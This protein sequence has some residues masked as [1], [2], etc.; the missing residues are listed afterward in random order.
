M[1]LRLLRSVW[2]LAW[3]PVRPMVPSSDPSDPATE[4]FAGFSSP[5][6]ISSDDEDDAGGTT[7]DVKVGTGPVL[8]GTANRR[9][10]YATFLKNGLLRGSASGALTDLNQVV[11]GLQDGMV[12]MRAAAS[13][14]SSSRRRSATARSPSRR[15]RPTRRSCFDVV[16]R[17]PVAIRHFAHQENSDV[18]FRLLTLGLT[19]KRSPF[20]CACRRA[21]RAAGA[22]SRQIPCSSASGRSAWTAPTPGISRRRSSTRS[23]RASP[24]RRRA[25]RRATG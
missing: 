15:F 1:R 24:A 16:L 18:P 23:A 17:R 14:S 5:I 8:A 22:G 12:G 13:G 3:I 20:V 25:T 7:T 6:V 4:T 11:R 10:Q 2:L 19:L 9:L 21:S